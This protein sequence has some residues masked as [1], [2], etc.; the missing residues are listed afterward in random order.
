MDLQYRY[1]LE[2]GDFDHAAACLNRLAQ[3]EIYLSGADTEKLLA[4]L[5]YMHSLNG[6]KELANECR[7]LCEN[8]LGT[9]SL[10]ACRVK[11]AY[12]QLMQDEVV[13]DENME[14]ARRLLNSEDIRGNAKFE[15]I[16]LSRI[17]AE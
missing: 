15:E 5:T 12:A 3:V 4:E 9:N 2:K 1:W 11:A 7:S 8:Y 13:R 10:T 14:M 17:S 6:D 16:L